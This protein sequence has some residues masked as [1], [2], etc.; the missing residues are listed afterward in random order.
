MRLLVY[1]FCVY[2]IVNTTSAE[3]NTKQIIAGAGPST[4]IVQHFAKQLANTE[5]GK[6]YD[7]VVPKMSAKHKGGINSV[8][9]TRNIF[10]RTGRPLSDEE[11]SLGVSEIIIGQVKI[12]FVAGPEIN[13]KPITKTQICDIFQGKL[14]SWASISGNNDSINVFTREPTE[15][16]LLTLKS[17]LPCMTTIRPD[18]RVFKK[19]HQQWIAMMKTKHGRQA[20]GFG[21]KN[22][23]PKDRIIPISDFEAGVPLGLVYKSANAKHPLVLTAK[24][25]AESNDWKK[26]AYS[27]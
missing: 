19:D 14:T 3:E 24:K 22:Y 15:A 4:N 5:T 1:F 2:L 27:E 16:L 20:I 11:K 23:Y 25:L 26:I 12:A 18:A 21:A 8:L 10:G 17:E 9:K 6:H 7:F 13:P